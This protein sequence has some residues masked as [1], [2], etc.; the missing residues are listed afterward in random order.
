ML[1]P[2]RFCYVDVIARL[3][4]HFRMFLKKLSPST[5]EDMQTIIEVL[6]GFGRGIEQYRENIER[7]V[8]TG[9]VG[10]VEECRVGLDCLTQM[11]PKIGD[12]LREEDIMMES[13]SDP[14]LTY[15]FYQR[16]QK[17][18]GLWSR[19][20]NVS[21]EYSMA[22]SLISYVGIPLVN[23]MRYLKEDHMKHCVPSNVSSGLFNRPLHYV[24]NNGIADV[25][26]P[27]S[28]KLP[29]GEIIDGK[30][31]YE[32]T[33]RFFTTTNPTAGK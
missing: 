3:P 8:R 4:Y 6:K 15:R 23:L 18:E 33:M 12:S 14:F 9:M 19:R 27:A 2:N 11:Y 21:L 10:S 13:F 32:R 7:G 30:A 31:G 25:S 26:K 28:R 5:I 24:Y 1:G 22:D 29:S 16:F 17:V 20:E